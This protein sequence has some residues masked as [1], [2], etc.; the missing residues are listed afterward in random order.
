MPINARIPTALC[1]DV[2]DIIAP[3]SDDAVL[4][5]AEMLR[6]CG[7]TGSFMVVGEKARLWELR[8]RQDVI[9]AVK[10]HDI[11]FH[12]TWHSLHPTTTELCLDK[13]FA[14][15]MSTLLEW[16]RKGIEDLQRIMGRPALGWGRTGS[17]WS[18]SVQGLMGRH[19][20]AYA[21]SLVRLPEHNVCWYAGCLSFYGSG[22]GDFDQVV[23]DTAQFETHLADVRRAVE[24]YAASVRRG[25][26]W[27]CLFLG[28]PTRVIHES[29]WDSVN[30]AKGANP[31]R[32]KWQP[33]PRRVADLLPTM[34]ANYRRICDWLRHDDSL[35]IVG[36]SE[37]IRR[38]D[39]QRPMC[40]HAELCAIA[41]RICNERE[42]IF[43]DHFTAAE[44]ILM[45]CRAVTAPQETYSRRFVYGP[46]RTPPVSAI[47][48]L[49]AQSVR[50]AAHH[51]LSMSRSG[52]LP[53]R[54]EIEA[55]DVGIGTIF[56]ALA[57]L[58]RGHE[59]LSGP[60]DAPYPRAAEEVAREVR[61]EIPRWIIHPEG[62]DLSKLAEQTLLQCWTL[63]PAWER[64]H[65]RTA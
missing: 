41:E 7:L 24:E 25:A 40:S 52:Y 57:Q 60:A 9:E 44:I 17:S 59:G 45:L 8:D 63:K 38:Y 21:Y 23:Y 4:W 47:S 46:L 61:Q 58:L 3:E 34:Q 49:S 50:E 18:P 31:P 20:R 11:G 33:A 37:L 2:E 48:T 32:D 22:I 42:V 15:G 54:V 65:L 16:D 62:M 36:W 5:L 27:L 30:F 55:R 43:S 28:H 1:L 56:V 64:Q 39:G 35:E 53:D 19:G 10:A 14:A 26:E 6:D 12:S 13:D 29:F 51:I